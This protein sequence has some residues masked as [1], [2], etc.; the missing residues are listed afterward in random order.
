MFLGLLRVI[1][2]PAGYP[3]SPPSHSSGLNASCRCSAF[4]SLYP[5]SLQM[6][7][8]NPPALV[9]HHQAQKRTNLGI[10]S[11][12]CR[13]RLGQDERDPQG[14]PASARDTL[15]D[16]P[17][18][19]VKKGWRALASPHS[20]WCG[21]SEEQ[22]PLMAKT[23]TAIGCPLQPREAETFCSISAWVQLD[24]NQV[25]RAQICTGQH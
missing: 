10:F 2:P 12:V 16:S 22:T 23:S 7:C 4:S 24:V 5:A 8:R 13:A 17:N 9:Q 6:P 25:C 15:P 20:W 11:K 21:L 3:L 19:N 18:V 14:Q 1:P